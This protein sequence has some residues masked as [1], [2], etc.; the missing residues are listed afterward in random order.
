MA[1]RKLAVARVTEKREVIVCDELQEEARDEGVGAGLKSS[2]RMSSGSALI[3]TRG[4]V[5]GVLEALT[6]ALRVRQFADRDLFG[7]RVA[8]EVAI[9]AVLTRTDEGL[10]VRYHLGAEGL[11]LD[12]EAQA[13]VAPAPTEQELHLMR[14]FTTEARVHERGITLYRRLPIS[15]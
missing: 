12:V 6:S 1:I 3:R 14:H 11:L 10:R 2:S 13:Y 9:E 4:D 5:R 15:G 8:L 7:V